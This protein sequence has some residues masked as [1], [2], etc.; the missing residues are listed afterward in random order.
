[1]SM[2]VWM[3]TSMSVSKCAT[4]LTDHIVASVLMVMSSIVMDFRAQVRNIH[5]YAFYRDDL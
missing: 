4:M 5:C 2:N 1:M 3:M